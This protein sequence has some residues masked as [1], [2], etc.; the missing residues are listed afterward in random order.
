MD[1]GSRVPWAFDR[2][3]VADLANSSRILVG[4]HALL[5][6]IP[7]GADKRLF[8]VSAEAGVEYRGIAASPMGVAAFVRVPVHLAGRDTR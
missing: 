5:A 8:A 7:R 2:F 1:V 4:I 6:R 3:L